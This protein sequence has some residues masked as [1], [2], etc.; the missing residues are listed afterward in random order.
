M[1]LYWKPDGTKFFVIDGLELGRAILEFS[2]PNRFNQTGATFVGSFS[3]A[4]LDGNNQSMYWRHDGL[5]C[6]ITT[7]GTNLLIQLDLTT[8]WDTSAMSDSGV[9]FDMTGDVAQANGLYIRD[10]GL[11]WFVSDQLT[12]E[13]FEYDMPAFD[14]VNS[15]LDSQT[16]VTG[17][18]NLAGNFFKQDGRKLY[19]C[20]RGAGSII[21][22]YD[23]FPPWD[24]STLV[25]IASFDTSAQ[26]T[27]VRTLFIKEDNGKK[28]WVIGTVQDT[29]FSYD[30][31][32]EFN[33]AII[34]DFFAEELT[35]DA[36]EIIVQG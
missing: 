13:I 16:V 8:A 36:G 17:V 30:M 20:D 29:L 22:L 4:L 9:T 19:V 11:K 23:L 26:E 28:L 18:I 24:S 12:E 15:V 1:Q 10:D 2:V 7:V 27:A 5:R 34:T 21:K 35:T 25:Q 6:Y 33:E 3:L 14:I 31:S 32:L